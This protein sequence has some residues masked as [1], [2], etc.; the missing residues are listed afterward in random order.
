MTMP[1]IASPVAQYAVTSKPHPGLPSRNN[2][3]A[4]EASNIPKTSSPAPSITNNNT[5]ANTT[6]SSWATVG[7]SGTTTSKTINL[8]T[9]TKKASRKFILLN[10][11][12]ERLDAPLPRSDQAATAR[13][14]ERVRTKKVRNNYQL[15]GRCEAGSYCDYD[16]GEKLSPGE[17]LALT[18]KART[19]SCP[20]GSGC[21]D[22]DCVNGHI[23]PYAKECYHEN[24][25][26]TGLHD[27]DTVSF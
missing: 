25:W 19:R 21:R 16:H 24:C 3:S 9:K 1:A 2:S 20:L 7:K 15:T 8:N 5:T 27:V 26:F 10:A 12:D 17:K 13:L 6:T 14:L 18:L 23:C 11:Y 4:A 22:F